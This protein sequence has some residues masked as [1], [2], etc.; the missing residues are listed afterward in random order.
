MF[1]E[2]VLACVCGWPGRGMGEDR[3]T[4]RSYFKNCCKAFFCGGSSYFQTIKWSRQGSN[5]KE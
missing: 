4:L 1:V 2:I 5:F 3:D